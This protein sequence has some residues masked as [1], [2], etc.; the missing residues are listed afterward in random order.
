MPRG[1]A[2]LD[3][4]PRLVGECAERWNLTLGP[5]FE[6]ATIAW[7]CEA[8]LADGTRAVLKVNFPEEE[9][10]HEADALARSDAVHADIVRCAELLDGI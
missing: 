8:A 6:P 3:E 2:W 5:P 10:E 4:L 9:S 7:V 1:A